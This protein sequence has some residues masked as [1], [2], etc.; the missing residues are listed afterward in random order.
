[1]TV[2]ERNSGFKNNTV[3]QLK[4]NYIQQCQKGKKN[5]SL[6]GVGDFHMFIESIDTEL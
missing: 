3:L 1:M 2:F 5:D 6:Q 4:I